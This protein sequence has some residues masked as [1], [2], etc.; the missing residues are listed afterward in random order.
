VERAG[1]E[2]GGSSERA[3]EREEGAFEGHCCSL[4]VL[5]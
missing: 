4:E 1:V 3:G 5:K 2:V